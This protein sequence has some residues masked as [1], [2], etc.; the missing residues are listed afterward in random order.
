M[1]QK[2]ADGVYCIEDADGM[3]LALATTLD[4][5]MPL[6][7]A[8]QWWSASRRML[9]LDWALERRFVSLPT[10]W[11]GARA[12]MC[13]PG[14]DAVSPPGSEDWEASAGAFPV[15]FICSGDP[16]FSALGRRHV[17]PASAASLPR[18]SGPEVR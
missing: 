6:R 2:V 17:T 3:P 15:K 7:V 5:G 14:P 12:G 10:W 13:R 11:S 4:D 9:G 18:P 1:W 16:V 8:E